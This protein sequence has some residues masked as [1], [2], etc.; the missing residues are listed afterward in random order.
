MK[1]LFDKLKAIF[2]GIDHAILSTIHFLDELYSGTVIQTAIV[3]VKQGLEQYA[4]SEI[5]HAQVREFA[6]G[7]VVKLSG[8]LVSANAAYALVS[9]VLDFVISHGVPLLDHLFA[10][11]AQQTVVDGAG[12]PVA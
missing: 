3:S 7:E 12:A 10:H 6:A 5:Q 1:A 8:G 4:V 2:V 11:Y 9:H